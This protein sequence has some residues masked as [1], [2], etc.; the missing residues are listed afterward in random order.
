MHLRATWAAVPLAISLGLTTA[1][2]VHAAIPDWVAQSNAL[3]MPV[4]QIPAKYEPET[5]SSFG[6]EEFDTE[7]VDLKPKVY[8]R[9]RAD[10]EKVLAQLLVEQKTTLPPKV[11]QDLEITLDAVHRNM[12]TQQLEHDLLLDYIDV[13]KTV[14]FGL[15]TLLEPRNKAD[16]QR[17]A[18]Q[19][20]NRYA[21]LEKGYTP[22]VDLARARTEENI[23]RAGVTGPYIEDL[24]QQLDNIDVMLDGIKEDF[25]KAG[26]TGWE[27]PFAVLSQQLHAY[28]DWARKT[29][30][31]LARKTPRPPAAI[32]ANDLRNYGVS[33]SPDELILRAGADYQEVKDSMRAVAARLAEQRNY[34]SADYHDVIRELKKQQVPAAEM[35]PHYRDTLAQI[36]AIIRREH[37][38]TL[39]N[40]AA[41]IR[42]ATDAESASVGSPFMNPPRLLGNTG[43]YGEFVITTSNPHA[44]SD[45]KMDDDTHVA[46]SWTLTAHEARPGHELQYSSMV[47]QGVS[48]P[49]AIFAENSAN[50]EGWAV[51]CEAMI[52]P[53]MP[54]DAQLI[55]LQ[56]RLMRV[57][58]A[59]LDPMINTGRI[60]PEEAKQVLMNDVVLSEPLAQSEIDRYAFNSPGQATAYYFGYTNLRSLL[61]QTQL[62]LGS[63]FKLQAF[64]DFV[65]KQGLLPPELMRK[66]VMEEF[67]PSQQ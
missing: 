55:S 2:A 17:R 29:L 18:L 37:L 22:L 66:A 48:I 61:T 36:E 16:R 46:A 6:Q 65:I 31:P 5:V 26:L 51:Y 67:V 60:T 24:N 63:K 40:R 1:T 44:K 58:R 47:E 35:L 7:V 42:P 50:V 59:F 33:I 28:G 11:R 41:H 8:E 38:I 19:R 9:R 62:V 4:M 13:P 34:K 27:Q 20:L 25:T 43:E 64:N 21:G 3:A 54:L 52:E 12:D 49:R 57:A 14:W 32:Y 15:D 45:A 10:S 23:Q 39:P 53:Y 30:T 56:N